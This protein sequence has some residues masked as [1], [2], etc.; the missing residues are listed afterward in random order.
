MNTSTVHLLNQINREFYQTVASSFDETRSNPW[1][2][3][4]RLLPY[5]RDCNSGLHRPALDI[6]DSSSGLSLRVLDIGCGNGRFGVFLKQNLEIPIK[7]HGIDSSDYLLKH[8]ADMLKAENV[9]FHLRNVDVITEDYIPDDP[10][11]LIVIF[12]V[13]HH[14]PGFENRKKLIER[15]MKALAPGGLLAVTFWVF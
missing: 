7:Y 8:A 2:G 12:G 10:Y 1:S 15:S 5:I 4:L 9:D 14:I 13:M 11:D 6:Q 3:W